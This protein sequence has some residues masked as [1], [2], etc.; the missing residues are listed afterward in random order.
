[1][2]QPQSTNLILRSED[3]SSATW[4]KVNCSITSNQ[5]I[6][7]DGTLNADLLT[8]TGLSGRVIQNVTYSAGVNTGSVFIK[9]SLITDSLMRLFDG[10]TTFTLS[11]FWVDGVPSLNSNGGDSYSIVNYGNDWY[12]IS[13]S[14]TASAGAGNM[15][16]YING[17]NSDQ[18]AYYWGAQLEELSYP[19]TYIPTSG[20]TATRLADVI[21]GAGST[22]SINSEEG[23]LFVEIEA[24]EDP[25]TVGAA[26][27]NIALSDGTINNSI[28]IEYYID[29]LIY[30]QYRVGGSLTGSTS[31]S[32]TQN[33]MNTVAFKWK[34]NDFEL[35][36]NGA[37]VATDVSGAVTAAN[38]MNT[39]EF[40][41]GNGSSNLFYGK[42]KQLR[43]YSSIADAQIDLPYIT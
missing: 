36:I 30:A 7:P 34:V 39:L 22:S 6:S 4:T 25:I 38:V 42:T 13:M 28:K 5:A 8:V 24:F 14:V 16:L 33:S 40:A 27:I 18:S 43:V 23:V 31:S 2:T 26:G 37:S 17:F 32:I 1:M 9:S 3:F 29:G 20:A 41:R 19:T 21:T 12:R 35:Y 11:L 15:Q 10:T